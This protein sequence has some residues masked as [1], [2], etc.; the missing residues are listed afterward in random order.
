MTNMERGHIL[1]IKT[2]YSK[3]RRQLGEE[4][5]DGSHAYYIFA[6]S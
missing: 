6:K 3:G 1:V 5:N 2:D 4:V